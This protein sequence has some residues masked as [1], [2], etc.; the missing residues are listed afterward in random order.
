MRMS[1]WSSD[2][3]SSDLALCTQPSLW[4]GAAPGTAGYQAAAGLLAAAIGLI[5][6]DSFNG[7]VG[8]QLGVLETL[9][10]APAAGANGH[11]AAGP[12]TT[13]FSRVDQ[14]GR[15]HV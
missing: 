3:C 9:G 5:D 14:I 7:Q 13:L 10:L 1:D 6:H 4:A 2:V 11:P 8:D 15:A 12:Q